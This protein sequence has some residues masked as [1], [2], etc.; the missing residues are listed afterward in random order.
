MKSWPFFVGAE[1]DRRHA[2][3]VDLRAAAL[4]DHLF[5]RLGDRLAHL[6]AGVVR[7]GGHRFVRRRIEAA[8]FRD[9]EID[10][11]EEPF[12][13]RDRRVHHAGDLRDDVA[14]RVAEG[15]VGGKVV[16]RIRAGEIDRQPIAAH[17]HLAV[18]VD[19]LVALGIVIDEGVGLVHAVA[20]LADFLAEAARRVVD[21]VLR[22]AAHRVDAVAGDDLLEAAHTELGGADLGAQ[23][24]HE[25]R[26][27]VVHLHEV[28]NVFALDA[29]LEDLHRREAHAFGPD[30]HR[31]DVVP[32]RHA[33]AGIGVV[34]LDRWMSTSSPS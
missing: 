10:R 32:A 12:I 14:A 20:P 17:R 19:V 31:I 23:I 4:G 24:A 34:A 21:H 3:L 1:N 26:R 22:R 2:H 30:V 27:A 25:G 8:A 11:V 29:A 5:E 18:D 16:A 7:A 28:R 15:R 13:L 6:G 33:A 9:D